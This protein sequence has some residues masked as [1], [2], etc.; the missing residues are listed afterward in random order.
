MLLETKPFSE[1]R[2]QDL[3]NLIIDGEPEGKKLD[4]KRELPGHSDNDKRKFLA[5]ICAF[6]N[7]GGGFLVYGMD[8]KAGKANSLVGIT[9][10]DADEEIRRLES[11]IQSGIAPRIPGIYFRFVDLSSGAKALIIKIPISWASPHMVVFDGVSRFYSRNSAGNYPLD[12]QE[13][14]T[15]FATS[16]T[17]STGIK[18]FRLNRVGRIVAGETPILI[19]GNAKII[20]HIIPLTSLYNQLSIDLNF[21]T[22]N[23]QKLKTLNKGISNFRMNFDGIVTYSQT[24][25]DK[26]VSYTQIFKNG[27]IEAVNHSILDKLINERFFIPSVLFEESVSTACFGLLEFQK[28][29]GIEPPILIFLTLL[30]VKGYIMGVNARLQSACFDSQDNLFIDRDTLLVPE[31]IVQNYEGI[32]IKSIMKPIFDS[33]WNAA[34]WLRSMNYDDNGNW[35]GQ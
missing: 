9:V 30:G 34:G 19:K 15:A 28:S 27:V 17:L 3:Q 31:V 22:N 33:V 18:N 32:N 11:I 7:A 13:I 24:S 23:Y 8:E 25:D 1:I 6:A 29:M 26:Y 16:E 21:V 4:Y 5:D 14:R 12:V 35:V 10:L 20:L 2:E